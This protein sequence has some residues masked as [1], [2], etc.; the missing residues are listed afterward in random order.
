MGNSRADPLEQAATVKRFWS[1]AKKRT[2]DQARSSH[3]RQGA[4]RTVPGQRPQTG[5]RLKHCLCTFK[6]PRAQV[7]GFGMKQ[8]LDARASFKLSLPGVIPGTHL[9]SFSFG[10]VLQEETLE[11]TGAPGTTASYALEVFLATGKTTVG[12]E[13]VGCRDECPDARD[14][15]TLRVSA[16]RVVYCDESGSD[17]FSFQAW[18]LDG[19]TPSFVRQ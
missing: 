4:H 15:A 8:S 9:L 5:A 16:P 12:R 6:S 13:R 7:G 1:S 3:P 19:V 14:R 11:R 18:I 10:P 2:L 17:A